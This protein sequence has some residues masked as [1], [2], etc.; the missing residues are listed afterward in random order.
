MI[1]KMPGRRRKYSTALGGAAA[2]ILGVIFITAIGSSPPADFPGGSVVVIKKDMTVSETARML[3]DRRAIRSAFLYKAYVALLRGGAGVQAGEYLLDRPESALRLAHRTGYGLSGLD[4]IRV[5]IPE[6]TNS[7]EIAAILERRIPHFDASSFRLLAK[8]NEG[9]LFPD[10]YYFHASST[11]EEIV[12]RMRETFDKRMDGIKADIKASGEDFSDILIMASIIEEEA[13]DSEDRRLISGILWKRLSI[14]MP[15]Q[16][17]APFYYIYGKTSSELTKDDLAAESGYNTYRNKGL[18]AGPIS[19]P[20]LD[21]IMA[22]L[23]P[24]ESDYLFYLADSE[25]ITHYAEDHDGHVANIRKY[26]Q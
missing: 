22:A 8:E 12:G 10:T 13:N 6:G 17:D 11:P 26:L 18:P 9:Y 21:A 24:A 2:L 7:G 1:S 16:V 5:T 25:G 19:N 4:K 14:G 15:L 3:G 20:G 23:T